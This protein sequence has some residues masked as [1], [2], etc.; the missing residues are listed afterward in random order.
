LSYLNDPY[1][2]PG[3]GYR[4]SNTNYLVLAM[5]VTKATGSGLSAEFRKRFWQ[6]LGIK[7]VC[8]YM[9]EQI[10]GNLAHVWGDNFENDGS[11]RDITFL[12]RASH[13]S[14]TY[15]SAGLFMTAEDL[16]HWSQALF[17]GKIISQASLDEKLTFV[18][19]GGYGLGVGR[20]GRSFANGEKAIG[21]GGGNIGTVSYMVY[22]PDYGVSIAAMINKFDDKCIRSIVKSLIK[23][24]TG[25]LS[26]K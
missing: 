21:H 9:E 10:P 3:K 5:I 7:N 23:I 26:Q 15:G 4:Y 12:P 16:A 25:H 8:L 2:P 14:I 22:L 18:E 1:F 24:V 17:R 19:S 6:S 20:F 13:E 11:M